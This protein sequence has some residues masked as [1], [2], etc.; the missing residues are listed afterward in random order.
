MCF[1]S[2]GRVI[3]GC[4]LRRQREEYEAS[5]PF[6]CCKGLRSSLT[7]HRTAVYRKS[8][9]SPEFSSPESVAKRRG[10]PV[11]ARLR[12]TIHTALSLLFALSLLACGPIAASSAIGVAEE[13]IGAAED[14]EAPR[15]APYDY[16]LAR[17]Y[18][19][20]AKLTD[21]YAEFEASEGFAEQALE[22]ANKAVEAA[23]DNALRQQV[24]QERIKVRNEGGT[25]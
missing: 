1:R 6:M 9:I 24:L 11:R 18:L 19:R 12:T 14:A 10:H 17:S 7:L 8:R 22:A 25:Q 23:R 15:L 3:E 2:W 20:K 21:G 16:W 13:A 5:D 4:G